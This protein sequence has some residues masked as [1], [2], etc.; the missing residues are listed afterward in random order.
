MVPEDKRSPERT[1]PLPQDPPD[2]WL[3]GQPANHEC[4]FCLL[5]TK[6]VDCPTARHPY[7]LRGDKG[8]RCYQCSSCS[9]EDYQ[10]T[11]TPGGYLKHGTK[12]LPKAYVR[13]EGKYYSNSPQPYWC[14]SVPIDMDMVCT[15]WSLLNYRVALAEIM[16]KTKVVVHKGDAVYD[17]D[18]RV[19]INVDV[20][21]GPNASPKMVREEAKE[22]VRNWLKDMNMVWVRRMDNIIR[23]Q[24]AQESERKL[25]EEMEAFRQ[26]QQQNW[27]TSGGLWKRASV[28][29]GSG[30]WKGEEEDTCAATTG[31]IGDLE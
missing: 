12:E 6:G 26:D 1:H 20:Y 2:R 7:N 21:M 13:P 28:R 27:R 22:I 19:G 29:C 24:E 15:K 18:R 31:G 4:A 11:R 8:L 23:D 9:H 3:R 30:G 10:P 16:Q 17:V 25:K 5:C 14:V